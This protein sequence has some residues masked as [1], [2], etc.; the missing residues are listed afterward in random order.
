MSTAFECERHGF[1]LM[2]QPQV[3]GQF[4]Q[5][6]HSARWIFA[7]L[8]LAAHSTLFC[9][10]DVSPKKE[11]THL[12]PN[13]ASVLNSIYTESSDDRRMAWAIVQAR[14]SAPSVATGGFTGTAWLLEQ[15][16]DKLIFVTA[17][18]VVSNTLF[19]PQEK[20]IIS[21][22]VWLANGTVTI[23][24]TV[25]NRVLAKN[26]ISFLVI[27]TTAIP[28]NKVLLPAKMSTTASLNGR[29]VYNLGYPN[30]GQKDIHIGIDLKSTP[31][32]VTFS[33][34]PWRQAGHVVNEWTV[35]MP[36]PDVTLHGAKVIVLD[37]TSEPGFSGGPLLLKGQDQIV[38]M[39]SAVLPNG[40]APPNQSLA[41]SMEEILEQKKLS[42]P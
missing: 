31:P 38:G 25:T 3:N 35:D 27:P 29:E 1:I 2:S 18:H 41:I 4:C 15:P 10:V 32:K 22:L 23:P 17:S 16:E 36:A 21:T 11:V 34:G 28:R 39:M 6:D 19:Y 20:D 33:H 13:Q 40:S 9:A 12:D 42:S 26:D 30:R 8:V 14:F 7:T 24:I 37:Y 5:G